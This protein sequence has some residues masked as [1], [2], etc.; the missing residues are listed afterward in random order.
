[1][2]TAQKNENQKAIV[3]IILQFEGVTMKTFKTS[4]KKIKT[5]G[6]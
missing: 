5:V 2:C 1:M 3:C 4:F 6:I